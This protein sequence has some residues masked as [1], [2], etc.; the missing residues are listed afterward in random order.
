MD[1]RTRAIF[2]KMASRG[3][4]PDLEQVRGSYRFDIEG[5]GSWHVTVDQG[6]LTVTRGMADADCVIHCDESD[7]LRLAS[8]EQ[9]LV[10]AALQGRVRI[11]GNL[12]LAQKLHGF[13]RA[14]RP[15]A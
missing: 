8:G 4:D 6:T 14:T 1:D 15:A 7:F 13:V 11:E 12:A 2:E 9:N 5:V 10:T 3:H